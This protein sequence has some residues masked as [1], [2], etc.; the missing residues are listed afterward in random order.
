[1]WMLSGIQGTRMSQRATFSLGVS[2]RCGD[3]LPRFCF[4][5]GL[6]VQL[7]GELSIS[8]LLEAARASGSTL[9]GEGASLHLLCFQHLVSEQARNDHFSLLQVNFLRLFPFWSSPPEVLFPA[10]HFG[11]FPCLIPFLPFFS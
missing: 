9:T 7:Q 1:M 2:G 5:E 10:S 11:F 8:T 3:V 6:A 4:K